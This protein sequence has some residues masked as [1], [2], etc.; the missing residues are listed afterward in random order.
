MVK[1]L[2]CETKGLGFESGSATTILGIDISWFQV[3][4]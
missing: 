3:A 4:I 2:A 1:V